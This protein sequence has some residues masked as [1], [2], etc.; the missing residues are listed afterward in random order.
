MSDTFTCPILG[1]LVPL[2]WISGDVFS[3]FQSQSGFFLIHIAEANVMYIPWKPALV[4]HIANLL[5]DGIAGCWPGSYLAQGYYCH[6]WDSN[7]ESYDHEFYSARR[8]GKNWRLVLQLFSC[9]FKTLNETLIWLVSGKLTICSGQSP[10]KITN[11]FPIYLS[12]LKFHTILQ[13]AARVG[14]FPWIHHRNFRCQG[15]HGGGCYGVGDRAAVD[16]G[17]GG[18]T[19][20]P[21]GRPVVSVLG[22]GVF[23]VGVRVHV[24]FQLLFTVTLKFNKNRL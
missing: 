24:D 15:N 18:Y 8:P 17:R 10:L 3:G 20:V 19:V 11:N 4:L 2:F 14:F 5:M 16:G 12:T 7:P 21:V 1:P 22:Q 9:P 23:R 6:K 13:L